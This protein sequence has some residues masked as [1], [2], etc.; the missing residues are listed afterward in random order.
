LIQNW[1]L[2][3]FQRLPSVWTLNLEP[4]TLDV[5]WLQVLSSAKQHLSAVERLKRA[6]AAHLAAEARVD[7]ISEGQKG[8]LHSEVEDARRR[9][10]RKTTPENW[11]WPWCSQLRA[12]SSLQQ[13][14]FKPY[15]STA[16]SLEGAWLDIWLRSLRARLAS[17]RRKIVDL[18]W[19]EMALDLQLESATSLE[20]AQDKINAMRGERTKLEVQ[21]ASLKDRLG[22][23]EKEREKVWPWDVMFGRRFAVSH[24]IFTRT[25]IVSCV[26]ILARISQIA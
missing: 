21:V 8:Q 22:Q 4:W 12:A 25:R 24:R 9:Q 19:L 14:I 10:A 11:V 26:L 6:T 17:K 15:F 18:T 3:H 1:F 7:E 20:K 16:F 13:P 5:N 2:N 23:E